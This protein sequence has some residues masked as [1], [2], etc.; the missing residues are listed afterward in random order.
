MSK[1]IKFEN[2]QTVRSFAQERGIKSFKLQPYTNKEGVS[3]VGAVFTVGDTSVWVPMSAKLKETYTTVP[4]D[5]IYIS[6][7]TNEDGEQ[8]QFV[9]GAGTTGREIL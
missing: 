9:H 3:N 4:A 5:Q 8:Y 6:A 2:T 7:V 1:I